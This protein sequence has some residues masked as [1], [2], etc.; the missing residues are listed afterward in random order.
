MPTVLVVDDNAQNLTL[1]STLPL[2][3]YNVRAVTGG[4]RALQAARQLPAPDLIVL[5]VMMPGMDG[6]E[7]LR[8]LRAQSATA[9]IPVVFVTAMD[10]HDDEE[11]RLRLGAVGYIT[12][13]IKPSLA[14]AR[15]RTQLE[16]KAARDRLSRRNAVLEEELVRRLAENTLVQDV[17]IHALARL[18]EIRDLQ[19]GNPLRR[20]QS[21]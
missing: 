1:L 11:R 13:P 15:I 2:P 17:R 4:P 6:L 12:K 20:G 14:L 10:S 3:L 5:D 8:Q 9:H 19:T 7:V 21:A 18:A 16:L